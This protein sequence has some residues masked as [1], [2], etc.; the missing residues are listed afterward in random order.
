MKTKYGKSSRT[1]GRRLVGVVSV[2]TLI[3]ALM[4]GMAGHA[5]AEQTSNMT[6]QSTSS[7]NDG[8]VCV[9]SGQSYSGYKDTFNCSTGAKYVTFN[10]AY[11]V[12]NRCNNKRASIGWRHPDGVI[13]FKACLNPNDE[14]PLVLRFNLVY[15]ADLG[16]RC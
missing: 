9:W 13:T 4:P 10:E 3:A 12:K 14:I 8:N 1:T 2:S 16:S 6:P 11:S 15:V 7:C 5:W